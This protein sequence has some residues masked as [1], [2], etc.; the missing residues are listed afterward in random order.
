MHFALSEE[1]QLLQRQIAAFVDAEVAPRA[2]AIDRA[3]EFPRELFA[4]FG[5]LGWFGLRHPEAAGGAGADLVTYC[6]FIEEVARGSLS[7]AAAVAMQSLMGTTFVARFGTAEH[8]RRLLAPAIAGEK[9]GTLAMTEPGAG[10]DL[11]AI[12]TAA[13]RDGDGWV[14]DGQKTW[15]TNAAV[16]DFVTVAAMVDRARGLNGIDLFLVERGTPGFHVGN[17]IEKL[18]TRGTATAELFF[19]GCRVPAENL[20]GA[21]GKGFS[22]LRACLNDIRIMTAAL[23]LGLSRAAL[24]DAVAYANERRAFGKRIAEF[25]GVSHQ[26]ARVAAELDAARWQTYHAAWIA[27]GVATAGGARGNFEANAAKWFATEV[28]QRAADVCGRVMASYGF[29]MEYPAQRYL[30]DARFLLPG[31]GTPEICLNGIAK[32]IGL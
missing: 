10:S 4:R 23:G 16:A 2:A 27:D 19:E 22:L 18:G 28:A 11:A 5:A 24:A 26:I 9:I 3:G 32:E 31:G 25:Q 30:R 17:E 8:H 20:L 1:Q 7:V 14:L 29:A 6:L 21:P 13:R 12:A 15:V